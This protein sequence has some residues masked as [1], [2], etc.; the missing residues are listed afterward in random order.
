MSLSDIVFHC[1]TFFISLL[2]FLVALSLSVREIT[3][4]LASKRESKKASRY[5]IPVRITAS[6]IYRDQG[7]GLFYLEPQ[8]DGE[9]KTIIARISDPAKLAKF[10]T[11]KVGDRLHII[12]DGAGHAL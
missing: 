6:I 1:V 12:L 7:F 11:Y 8:N 2:L 9:L 4:L 5:R 3:S 10:K